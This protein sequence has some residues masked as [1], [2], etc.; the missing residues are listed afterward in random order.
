MSNQGWEEKSST[1][2]IRI[3]SGYVKHSATREEERILLEWLRKSDENKRFF[4]T[5]MAN[6][7]LHDAIADRNL[8]TDSEQML[9]RLN[10]RIDA[11]EGSGSRKKF[12]G[13]NWRYAVGA[14]AAAVVICFF[15]FKGG[16]NSIFDRAPMEVAANT[17]S[18]VKPVSLDDGS[19]VWL[20]PNSRIS[21]N[22]TGMNGKR[23]VK[24]EGN[25]YFDVARDEN[26]PFTVQTENISVRVLGTAFTVE[27]NG[28]G[29]EVVLERGSVRILS[30]EGTNMVTLSPNQKAT[31]KSASGD[32]NIEPVYASSIVT[33]K[34]NLIAMYDV[35]LPK[36]ISSV[37]ARFGVTIQY[38]PETTDKLYN[39]S[40]L[41][42]DSL[43]TVMAI[44]E[45]MTG[46][47]YHIIRK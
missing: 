40:F 41:R 12:I 27:S 44:I 20:K 3:I 18:E 22:V 36:M 45:Y 39:I 16:K 9:S 10:A 14:I 1:D 19:K 24:L 30:P 38:Q 31:Y 7:S 47:K 2:I 13:I 33:Q 6:M 34:Y 4:T 15:L 25:A 46:I 26:R 11:E 35:T 42:T 28:D 21:Y 37:E 17:T 23:L 32:I 5:L 29:A 8:S 43:G